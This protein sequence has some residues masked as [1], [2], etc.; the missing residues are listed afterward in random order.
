MDFELLRDSDRLCMLALNSFLSGLLSFP[1]FRLGDYDAS[2]NKSLK[3]ELSSRASE[4]C[5]G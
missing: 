4:I 3:F 5:T 1:E 2:V